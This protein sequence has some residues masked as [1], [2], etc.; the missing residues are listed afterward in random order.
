[1]ATEVHGEKKISSYRKSA[2]KESKGLPVH[3]I[4][5]IVRN[6]EEQRLSKKEIVAMV[7]SYEKLVKK[8]EEVQASL[9]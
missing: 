4:N 1:M 7:A 2:R 6:S 3:Y 5:E 9:N 8:E